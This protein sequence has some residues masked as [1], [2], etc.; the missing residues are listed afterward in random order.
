[1]KKLLVFAF[2]IFTKSAFAQKDTVGINIP[3]SNNAV[4][5]EKVFDVPNAPKNLL[6]S[7]AALW[8]AQ[9]HPYGGDTQLRLADPVLS[10]VVG[11]VKSSS[12]GTYKVLW[13]TQY[14]TFDFDF[15]LQVDCK[16]NK[17]RIRV[18]N[19]QDVIDSKV[20]APVDGMMQAFSNGKSFLLPTGIA[21]GA[22]ALKKLFQSLNIAVNNVLT[23]LT[24]N[25]TADNSF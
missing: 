13:Q 22:D 10:R 25:M 17:Y 9:T 7:N 16:D 23:D 18:Y 5:Y 21:M 24:I 6:Y 4:V 19:I 8:F 12:G 15:T 1:M 14:Y 3:F 2:I 20:S 11:R